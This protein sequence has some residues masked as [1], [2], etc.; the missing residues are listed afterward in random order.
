MD[1]DIKQITNEYM[2]K[3]KEKFNE[4]LEEA[5]KEDKADLQEVTENFTREL[6]TLIT[7]TDKETKEIAYQNIELYKAIL[8]D[9]K[10]IESLRFT[11]LVL[12][13]ISIGLGIALKV[14]LTAI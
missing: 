11:N 4:A 6:E 5:K 13:G 8:L 1:I 3:M 10:A 12:D 9:Y 2:D 7:A 14:A